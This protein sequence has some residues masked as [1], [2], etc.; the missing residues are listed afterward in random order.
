[1]NS[2]EK[3]PAEIVTVD[4]EERCLHH[5]THSKA[6]HLGLK[7]ELML[8]HVEPEVIELGSYFFLNLGL[9]VVLSPLLKLVLEK[10]NVRFPHKILGLNLILNVRQ[11][12][13]QSVELEVT[14]TTTFL[15][16]LLVV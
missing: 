2:E 5:A 3:L 1:M 11:T 15:S 7:S 9:H 10:R 13:T 4:N 16:P 6:G 14:V 12:A 8:L